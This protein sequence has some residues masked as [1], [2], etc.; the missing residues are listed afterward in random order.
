MALYAVPDDDVTPFPVDYERVVSALKDMNYQ[1][2]DI[3]EGRAA[4]GVFDGVPFLFTFDTTGR[5]LSVRALW[6][7]PLRATENAGDI[8]TVVDEWNRE[9]Y[10]PTAYWIPTEDGAI[11]VCA[12]YV[13][14]TQ[15]GLSKQ[16]LR[17]N[18]GSGIATGLGAIEYAK[19]GVSECLGTSVNVASS[20]SEGSAFGL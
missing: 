3:V 15:A 2:D 18:L 11:Q 16:Q 9:K 7:T 6:G 10:F 4:G 13:V 17:E 19:E 1:V 14:D 8:F 20:P 5:F 12:D